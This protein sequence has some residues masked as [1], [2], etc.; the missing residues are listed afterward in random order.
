MATLSNEAMRH[1]PMIGLTG[2][3][4]SGKT[5]AA[6]ILVGLGCQIIDAD[7]L[8]RQT[9]AAGGAAIEPIRAFF[10]NAL[11]DKQGA[12]DRAAMRQLVF[13]DR[14]A[15]SQLEAIIHPLVRHAMNLQI[16]VAR[17]YLHRS[18]S[19]PDSSLRAV[20]LDL[21]LLAENTSFSSWRSQ[22]DSIWVIDCSSLVQIARVKV[23]SGLSDEQIKAV[24]ANQASRTERNKIADIVINNDGI[25]IDQL[26]TAVISASYFVFSTREKLT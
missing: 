10:G 1:I 8:S 22:L 24:M 4:G 5:S 23:R 16:E 3:I 7:A 17:A 20:V 2:G 19:G 18:A 12:L 21:P 11:I 14:E 13:H 25:T 26:K 6:S 9:T 15:K